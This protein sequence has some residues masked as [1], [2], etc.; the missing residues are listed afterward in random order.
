MIYGGSLLE[1]P[2]PWKFYFFEAN[3]H[4]REITI[5]S[6]VFPTYGPSIGAGGHHHCDIDEEDNMVWDSRE[7][8]WRKTVVSLTDFSHEE[9]TLHSEHIKGRDAMNVDLVRKCDVV[10]WAVGVLQEWGVLKNPNYKIRWDLDDDDP[11]ADQERGR[12]MRK[13]AMER[14]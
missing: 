1:V 10:K 9:Y 2:R 8:E 11:Y 13:R 4:P 3:E 5:R 7:N 14:D 6:I 12:L